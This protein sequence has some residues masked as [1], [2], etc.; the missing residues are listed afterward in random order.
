MSPVKECAMGGPVS[1]PPLKLPGLALELAIQLQNIESLDDQQVA[2][3]KHELKLRE[4][5]ASQTLSDSKHLH[6]Q[7]IR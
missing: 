6:V 2:A 1:H 4:E 7:K 3:L 5:E